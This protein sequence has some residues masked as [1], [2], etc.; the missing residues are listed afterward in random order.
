MYKIKLNNKKLEKMIKNTR[1]SGGYSDE[2]LTQKRYIVS[3]ELNQEVIINIE[4]FNKKSLKNA[5][6]SFTLKASQGLGTWLNDNK[7]YVDI[8][9]GFDNLEEAM[10]I[11]IA[12]KQLAI[13]DTIASEAI[14]TGIV[15]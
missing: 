1:E 8:N 10:Q 2:I 11:A 6:K 13:Y 4:D 5:I 12:N 9:Q 14:P 15:R 3:M 7:V